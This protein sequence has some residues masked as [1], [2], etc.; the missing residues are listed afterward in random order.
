MNR[1]GLLWKGEYTKIKGY[2]KL[3]HHHIYNSKVLYKHCKNQNYK[4]KNMTHPY[5]FPPAICSLLPSLTFR[6]L[7]TSSPGHTGSRGRILCSF[8]WLSQYLKRDV[9]LPR[10]QIQ[11]LLVSCRGDVWNGAICEKRSNPQRALHLPVGIWICHTKVHH[12]LWRVPLPSR[13]CS[14]VCV[15]HRG[16]YKPREQ[17]DPQTSAEL[18]DCGRE[19]IW[20]CFSSKEGKGAFLC[21]EKRHIKTSVAKYPSSQCSHTQPFTSASDSCCLQ[22]PVCSAK[23]LFINPLTIPFFLY[24]SLNINSK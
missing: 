24:D 23:S 2:W 17:G 12:F 20:L 3:L 19:G 15:V 6:H 14:S 18:N 1:K 7:S 16:P 8:W 21:R 22:S 9:C 11:W 13:G 5:A 10:H 4:N